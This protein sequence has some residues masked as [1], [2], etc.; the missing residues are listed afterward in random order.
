MADRPS[1]F[2]V[3]SSDFEKTKRL[4]DAEFRQ[5]IIACTAYAETGEIVDLP[6]MAALCF[7][8]VKGRIDQQVDAYG[9]RCQANRENGKKGGRPPKTSITQQNPV[10]FSETQQNPQ[11]PNI[12]QKYKTEKINSLEVIEGSRGSPAEPA[13]QGFQQGFE[14]A[15]EQESSFEEKREAALSKIGGWA[16]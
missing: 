15:F 13:T 6:P 12:K 16:P 7:D 1:G 11:N 3:F 9:K 2:I 14:Q 5:W 10:G 8:F 4:S